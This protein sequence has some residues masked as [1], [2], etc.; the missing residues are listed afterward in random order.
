MRLD[1][2]IPVTLKRPT[3]QGADEEYASAPDTDDPDEGAGDHVEAVRSKE[4]AA[5]EADE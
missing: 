1:A 2:L 4:Y 5:I 3:L